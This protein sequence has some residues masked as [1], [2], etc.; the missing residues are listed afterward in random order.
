MKNNILLT[1]EIRTGKTVLL[2]RI[3]CD[4]NLEGSGFRTAPRYMDDKT[5]VYTLK[6]LNSSVEVPE[7]AYIFTIE[8]DGKKTPLI[9]TFENYGVKILKGC[10]E[11]NSPI[12]IMDELGIFENKA[13]LF[14]KYV[15][16]C[17]D[18]PALVLGVM[19]NKASV[20]LN[21]IRDR[22]DVY[23]IDVTVENREQ[24]YHLMKK[25][26]QDSFACLLK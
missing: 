3:L 22:K 1:G 18:S 14:Q 15:Y 24:K 17:L 7:D 19:K 4:L 26:I 10:L 11:K 20:F 13:M 2:N 16:K 23:I 6:P 8:K 9:E 21:N 12:I 5:R 25:L